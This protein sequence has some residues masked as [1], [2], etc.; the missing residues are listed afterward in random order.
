[1]NSLN[2]TERANSLSRLLGLLDEVAKSNLD[3]HFQFLPLA[4]LRSQGA[5]ARLSVPDRQ[6]I[7]MSLNTFKKIAGEFIDGGFE[8]LDEAR[9]NALEQLEHRR[10]LSEK[11]GRESKLAMRERLSD[12]ERRARLF[13]DDL[14]HYSRALQ[15]AMS[16]MRDYAVSRPE[17]QAR[18]TSDLREIY[19]RIAAAR[20]AIRAIRTE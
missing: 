8:R 15:Y 18:L 1:M 9:R 12:A 16:R 7:G 2:S 11:V 4:A 5:L 13:Q 3:E 19:G 14:V 10:R 6:I 20:T 17:L